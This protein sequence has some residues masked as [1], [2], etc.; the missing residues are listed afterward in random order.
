M[1]FDFILEQFKNKHKTI[2]NID[3]LKKYIDFLLSYKLD[4]NIKNEIYCEE[5]HILP[6]CKF[7][8]FRKESW[9]L[10]KLTYEDHKKVHLLLF[11]AINIR[12]YQRPLN[13]M[14]PY[15]KNSEKTSNAAK[16]GWINLKN[17]KEVYDKWRKSRSNYMKSL[18]SKEQSRR[19]NIFWKNITEEQYNDFCNS[20]RNIWTK[21]LREKASKSHKE[22]YK[23]PENR[24]KKSK[25]TKKR[26][27]S[28]SDIERKQFS[29]KMNLIN[30]DSNKKLDAS[31]KI[32]SLWSNKEFRTKMMNRKSRGGVKFKIIKPNGNELIVESLSKFSKLYNL[33]PHK[34]RK[35]AESETPILEKDLKNNKELLGCII[36]KIN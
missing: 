12:A 34:I 6:N 33:S 7:P 25:E 3:E 10:I 28:M 21:E 8:E 15:Y 35:Y 31:K 29:D 16:I 23:N 18:S 2:H 17:N 26:W 24:K 4:E 14:L 22:Y 27:D 19:S 9:N 1:T 20:M 36:K 5:H 13:F 32:K 30:N 11:N